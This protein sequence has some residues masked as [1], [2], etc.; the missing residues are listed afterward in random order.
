MLSTLKHPSAWLPVVMSLSAILF[1]FGWGFVVGFVR[2]P[3]EGP[4]AHLFWLLMG[5]QI[6]IGLFFAATWLPQRPK[7]A[8]IILAL[9][10]ALWL[11]AWTP[12]WYFH[13]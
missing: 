9:Q 8:F 13:L 5:L 10:A 2:Q 1:L 4:G 11:L 6:P 7:P 3:D 12:V